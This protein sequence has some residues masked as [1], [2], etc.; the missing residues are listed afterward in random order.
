MIA[1]ILDEPPPED[2]LDFTDRALTERAD[3]RDR[4]P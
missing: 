2:P 4:Q 1:T 3:L